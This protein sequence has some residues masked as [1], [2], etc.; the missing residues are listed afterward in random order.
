[1][2]YLKATIA[3]SPTPAPSWEKCALLATVASD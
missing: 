1:M 2:I 3:M